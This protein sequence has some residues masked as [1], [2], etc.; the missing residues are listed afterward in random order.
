MQEP[1]RFTSLL[2]D[3]YLDHRF[4]AWAVTAAFGDNLQASALRAAEP[5]QLSPTQLDQLHQLGVCIN[6]NA[7]GSDIEDLHIPPDQLYR[8]LST[9]T[10]PFEF[11]AERNDLYQALLEAYHADMTLADDVQAEFANG[12]VAVFMLPDDKWARRV[13]GVWSNALANAHPARAHAVLSLT[14]AGDYQVSVRAPLHH[15]TGADELCVRFPTGGGRKAAA[16]I[17]HLPATEL[18]AF[19]DAL[20]AQYPCA[21]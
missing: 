20:V 8:Q 19:I 9:Y 4:T 11:I 2:V 17:N 16:G 6:Y 13:S 10:S 12:Q 5:L 1:R 18:F 3:R 15:R 14:A 21:E 7:Y